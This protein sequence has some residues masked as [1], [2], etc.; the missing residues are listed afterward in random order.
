MFPARACSA[1]YGVESGHGNRFVYVE[2][3]WGST[4][5]LITCP[6]MQPYEAHAPRPKWRA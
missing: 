3:P 1:T 2:T 4:L 5:E 6:T